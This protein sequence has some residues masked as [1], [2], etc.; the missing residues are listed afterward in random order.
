MKVWV[1][2]HGETNLNKQKFMQGI[3]DE[4]LNEIGISQAQQARK[5]V[6]NIRFD[7]VYSS[8][9]CRAVKTASI[10]GGVSEDE[11]I[12]DP[13]IIEV[14]FGKYELR[15]FT[16]IGPRLTIHWLYPEIFPAPTTVETPKQIRAR[17][18]A[19]IDELKTKDYE[20]VLICSHGYFMRTFG[21]M[22]ANDGKQSSWKDFCKN[23]EIREYDL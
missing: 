4:P 10:I 11:V 2:R 12:K 7:A 13:R 18:Q 22:L 19:F 17:A 15:K 21:H 1:V 3:T 16:K 20:N 14:N 9:L 5:T 6:E 8:T 23:C